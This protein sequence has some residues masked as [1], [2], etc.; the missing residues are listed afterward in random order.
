MKHNI[1]VR[2][3]DQFIKSIGLRNI[4]DD[5]NREPGIGIRRA[6]LGCLVLGSHRGDD[7][8]S[9]LDQNLEDVGWR[10]Q[11]SDGRVF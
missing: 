9:S 7:F 4:G 10:G 2:S 11:Q 3:L 5:G 6:D 1:N 8:V